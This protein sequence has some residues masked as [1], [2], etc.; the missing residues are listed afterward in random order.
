M[1]LPNQGCACPLPRIRCGL[2]LYPTHAKINELHTKWYDH[3][4]GSLRFRERITVKMHVQL[5]DFTMAYND[6][7]IGVPVLFIHGYPLNRKMW[8]PQFEG[9]GDVARLIAPDLRGHGESAFNTGYVPPSQGF[10][11]DMLADDCAALLEALEIDQPVVFCGLSMGGYVAF[12]FYRRYREKVRGLILAATRAGPDSIETKD[13]RREAI[14]LAEVE[15]P[16]VI[17]EAMLPN[18]LSSRTFTHQ[19]ETVQQV[20]E[21]MASITIDGMVGDLKGMMERPDSISTL[22]E[23]DVPTLILFGA[24]DKIINLWEMNTLRE[25]IPN[26]AAIFIPYAGHL[27]NLEQPDTFNQEVRSFLTQFR[28]DGQG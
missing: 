15:G 2:P 13:T 17:T 10:S 24:D 8:E 26:A 16:E 4:P 25:G 21:I 19:P 27:P 1:L 6:L 7:G 20:A 18:V 9:L 28:E 3:T 23:I 14:A 22:K 11:M 12:A 5:P